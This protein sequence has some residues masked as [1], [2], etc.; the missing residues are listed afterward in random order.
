MA[1]ALAMALW[2]AAA[3][4]ALERGEA[5]FWTGGE[6]C[7]D[8]CW[9][10]AV[11]VG[12]GGDWLRV[13]IDHV[14]MG[15]VWEAEVLDPTGNRELR[16]TPGVGRYS[17]EGRVASPA[18]GRWTVR[19]TADPG[20]TDLRFRGRAKL[21]IE[22]PPPSPLVAELPNLQALP[23][24]DLSFKYPLTNGTSDPPVGLELPGGRLA[25]HPEELLVGAVRCLRMAFGVRNTGRGP[26]DLSL[27][28]GSEPQDRPLIQSIHRTDGTFEKRDAGLARFHPSHGHYH[29]DEAIGLELLRVAAPGQL[30]PAAAEHRKGFAHRDE[31][32]REWDRFHPATE[33]NGFGLRAGWGDYYEWDRPGNYVDF[34]VNGDGRYVLR[35]TADPVGGILE[36]NEADNVSY[37]LIEVA[38]TSV[39]VLES[40]RGR[41]PWDRC[42]IPVPI[43]PEFSL[44]DG[45]V[46]RE[47]PGDCPPDT[48]DPDPPAAEPAPAATT[49]VKK[50]KKK[51]RCAK[52][53]TKK[54]RKRCRRRA[55]RGRG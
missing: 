22:H 18:P 7:G 35:M 11:D 38:G 8:R 14:T 25:C 45:V 29:H 31:L 19:V 13:G 24:W 17:Q 23:P 52:K 5:D 49:P 46:A 12:A 39:R 55:A 36:S 33:L 15:E 48:I 28:P 27:G 42:R 2:P 21:E 6:S 16:I 32:L 9:Q 51:K 26:M 41:D 20:V 1:A 53:K 34:G 10:H 4:H 47:R 43:G 30:E 3:A 54:A 44:P 50:A 40:G 37:S